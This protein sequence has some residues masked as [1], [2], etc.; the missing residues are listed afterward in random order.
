MNKYIIPVCEIQKS[1]IYNLVIMANSHEDCE[2]KLMDKFSKFSSAL[3][4]KE[5]LYDLDMNDILIGEINDI[6]TL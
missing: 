4:Y 2:D 6:E 1:K 3:D 5:F